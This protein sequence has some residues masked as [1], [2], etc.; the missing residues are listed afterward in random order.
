[1]S[2]TKRFDP[3]LPAGCQRHGFIWEADDPRELS[4]D[5]LDVT[6]SGNLMISVGWYDRDVNE[7][8]YIVDVMRGLENLRPAQRFLTAAEASAYVEKVAVEL[9]KEFASEFIL[10]RTFSEPGSGRARIL[11]KRT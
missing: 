8:C 1:M 5:M 10:S 9:R 3:A 6:M 11:D 4:E 7:S 2:I